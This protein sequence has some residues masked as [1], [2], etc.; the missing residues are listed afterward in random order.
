VSTSNDPDYKGSSYNLLVEWEDGSETLEPLDSVIK[1]DPISVANYAHE[2]NLLDTP[3]W[4]CL[5]RIAINKNRL[6]KMAIQANVSSTSRKGP[7]YIIPRNVKQSF[8]LDAKNGNTLWKDAM[9]K[10]IENIQ[11]YQTFKDMGKFTHVSG[12]KKIIVHFVFVVQH[13]L[14]HKPRLVAGGQ[15]TPP[16]M[17]G[18]YSSVVSLCSLRICLVTAELNILYKI[19]V[20]QEDFLLH[21]KYH[22][23]R[24]KLILQS[25]Y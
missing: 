12:Y 1:D 14:R 7:V 3:G 11:S 16:T 23:Y 19:Q 10:D 13:D 15:L 21:L 17:E 22:P 25:K 6:N 5:K 4:K 18:S 24:M 20:P 2:N 9:T 8:E